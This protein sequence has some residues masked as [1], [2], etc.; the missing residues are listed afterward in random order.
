MK[1][2]ILR[3]VNLEDAPGSLASS[4]HFKLLDKVSSRKN[5]LP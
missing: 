3:L 1:S 5:I 4:M 2:L